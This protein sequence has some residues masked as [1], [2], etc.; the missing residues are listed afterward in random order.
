[1]S[2]YCDRK[3]GSVEIAFRRTG[4]RQ[5][6]N[7]TSG[8]FEGRM[9]T[10]RIVSTALESRMEKHDEGKDTIRHIRLFGDVGARKLGGFGAGQQRRRDQA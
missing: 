8:M 9:P 1:M 5:K 7:V 2:G 6:T 10:Q 3:Y 4:V